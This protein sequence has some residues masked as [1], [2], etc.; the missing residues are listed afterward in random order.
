MDVRGDTWEPFEGSKFLGASKRSA[1]LSEYAFSAQ[2]Q[3]LAPACLGRS[4]SGCARNTHGARGIR[5]FRRHVDFK[6]GV[7]KRHNVHGQEKYARR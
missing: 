2:A 5:A 3:I 1:A 7:P 4:K 6:D